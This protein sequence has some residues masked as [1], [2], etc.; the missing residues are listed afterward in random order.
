MQVFHGVNWIADRMPLAPDERRAKWMHNN[1]STLWLSEVLRRK[2]PVSNPSLCNGTADIQFSY[3]EKAVLATHP[4][5]YNQWI[6][7]CLKVDIVVVASREDL[8]KAR[9]RFK[10]E[11]ARADLLKHTLNGKLD[12]IRPVLSRLH[13][14]GL[15]DGAIGRG[16]YFDVNGYPSM[17]D[18]IDIIL[19]TN[20]RFSRTQQKRLNDMVT[21]SIS[22]SECDFNANMVLYNEHRIKRGSKSA[23]NFSFLLLTRNSRGNGIFYEKHVISAKTGISAKG[24]PKRESERAARRIAS[25][26]HGDDREQRIRNGKLTVFPRKPK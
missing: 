6:Y 16:S 15:I 1:T 14:A 4:R 5:P 21:D 17:H 26:I 12:A 18:D 25:L 11:K 7:D 24:L 10:A 22:K 20:R 19:L 8:R 23:P 9:E 2:Y 13:A 3:M